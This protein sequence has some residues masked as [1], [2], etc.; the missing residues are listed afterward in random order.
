MF[1]SE[2]D[3]LGMEVKPFGLHKTERAN[4]HVKQADAFIFAR[5]PIGVSYN[6]LAAML[7]SVNHGLVHWQVRCHMGPIYK[8]TLDGQMRAVSGL[9]KQSCLPDKK[10]ALSVGEGNPLH[11]INF[12]ERIIDNSILTFMT[13]TRQTYKKR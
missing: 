8:R 10:E 1:A 13:R 3:F 5:N 2:I 6:Q 11:F 4:N 7:T 12:R 9:P